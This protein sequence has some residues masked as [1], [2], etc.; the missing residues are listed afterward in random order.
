MTTPTTN[1]A[2][3]AASGSQDHFANAV[4]S[5][6]E[7]PGRTALCTVGPIKS[8]SRGELLFPLSARSVLSRIVRLAV[9]F[10]PSREM[11]VE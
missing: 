4:D 6:K 10:S 7:G 5:G 9:V 11:P 8:R 3:P 1:D 2:A